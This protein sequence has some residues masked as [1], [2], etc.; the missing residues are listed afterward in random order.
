M[1]LSEWCLYLVAPGDGPLSPPVHR[2]VLDFLGAAGDGGAI[3]AHFRHYFLHTNH[4]PVAAAAISRLL[5]TFSIVAVL[6]INCLR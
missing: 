1:G 2:L 5:F 3:S 6:C 4:S